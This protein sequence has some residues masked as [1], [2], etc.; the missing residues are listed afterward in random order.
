MR[1]AKLT[2]LFTATATSHDLQLQDTSTGTTAAGSLL[3]DDVTLTEDAWTETIPASTT[4]QA[5]VTDSVI[6]SQ[7]GRIIQNT[8]TDGT[9]V[10]TSAYSYDT[11]GR[12]STAII[13]RHT[14]TYTYASTGGCG[15]NPAA[16][17][18][19]NRT[20]YS[21][22]QD[23]G[24]PTTVSYCYDNADRLTSTNVANAPTGAS[25]V[26]GG[27]LS[28]VGPL[29]SL[30]YDA[31]GNTTVLAD[32]TLGYDV[33][34][35]HMTTTL[36]DGTTVAYVRDVTGRVVSRV[37]DAPGTVN[38]STFRYGF[39]AGGAKGNGWIATGSFTKHPVTKEVRDA[40]RARLRA[41]GNP[42][43]TLRP[44]L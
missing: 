36:S 22:T 3:V 31:H 30:V 43:P 1:W 33:A 15:A 34:D 37:T 32:Q 40:L 11:A 13:P 29:P 17:M 25:P 26:A 24:T 6:R 18:N 44:H 7:S 23:S 19:G 42:T 35:R 16:G 8:L 28:T 39:A 12:L 41:H 14:L 5:A 10:E 21:D 9:T 27:A 2:Y 38:D 4:A 20:A